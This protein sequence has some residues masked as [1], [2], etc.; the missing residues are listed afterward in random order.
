MINKKIITRIFFLLFIT[1]NITVNAQVEISS[2][3]V[4]SAYTLDVPGEFTLKS[5]I[6]VTFKANV[7]CDSFPTINVNSTGAILI[8]KEGGTTN[9]LDK[10]IRG[11]QVVNL[12][13]DGT[14]WQMLSASGNSVA[15]SAW[16]LTGNTGTVDG[17]NFIG[18][19]DNIPFNIRVNN[20][21]AGRID[22]TLFN[23]FFGYQAG[24]ANTTGLQNIASGGSSLLNNTTASR[25][26]AI[27]F[28]AL[29]TQSFNNAGTAWNT[30]NIAIGVE[31]LFLN[32]PTSTVNGI[33]NTAIGNYVLRFNTTGNY[34]SA[35]GMNA[36]RFNTT[37]NEN[38]AIGG[39]ALYLNNTGNSN[40]ANGVNALYSNTSGTGNM[41]LG[42]Q[43]GYTATP[44][45]ANT[46][47]SYNVFLGYNSGPGV[48][49]ASNLQNAIAIGKNALVNASNSMVL[50]GTGGD[51]VNVGVGTASPGK[52]TGASHYV[53]IAQGDAYNNENISLE[54]QGSTNTGI[55]GNVARIDFGNYTASS[56]LIARIESK[57]DGSGN[58]GN[59]IFSTHNGTALSEA[60]RVDN[61][62]QVGIGT[63]PSQKFEL[64]DGN[65]LVSNS[66]A[67]GEIRL[68]EPAAS[69]TNYT[70]F[71][72]P[73]QAANI[74]YTLPASL[75]AGNF[76][77][78]DASGNLSWAALP[79][80][81]TASNGLTK[82]VNDIQLGGTL[83]AN[84]TIS[85]ANFNMIYNLA[86]TGNFD[87]QDAGTSK[88]YVKNTGFVGINN[89]APSFALDVIGSGNG[90][91]IAA[92]DNNLTNGQVLYLS[93]AST[94]GTGGSASKIITI[95]RS[96]A[97]SIAS[98][99]AYGINSSVTNT[100]STS[101]NIS[102]YFFASG[103][104]NNY[105]IVVPS[106]G[107]KVGI[108]TTSPIAALDVV[109]QIYSHGYIVAAGSAIDWNN[110]NN[111][112][113]QAV[114]GG[115]VTF[116]NMQDGGNYTAII[117][118]ATSR[119]YTFSQAG[120]TFY[121][122]PPNGPTVAAQST[123]YRFNRIG[124]SVY[125]DWK[126]VGNP[127][128]TTWGLTGNSGTVDGTN[129]I[130][131][132]D[133]I[134][135]NFRVN[136]LKAGRIEP[137][138]LGSV[139]FGYLAGISTNAGTLNTA[140][141]AEAL[142][143]NTSGLFNTAIGQGALSA[144]VTGSSNTAN[145]V[146]ALTNSTGSNNTAIGE[147][148][149]YNNIGG[150]NNTA[151]GYHA[152]YTSSTGS[153][154]TFIGYGADLYSATQHSK[155]AAIGYNAKVDADNAI[156]LGG[157]GA[158][159]VNV[160]IGTTIPTSKLE[161]S[162][163]I[164]VG[165]G[166]YSNIR[167]H[168]ETSQFGLYS[169]KT[170]YKGAYFILN[171]AGHFDTPGSMVFTHGDY[172]APAPASSILFRY[173]NNGGISNDFAIVSSGNVGIGTI[174][175][176]SRLAIVSFAAD[177]AG[178]PST[179]INLLNNSNGLGPW[180]Q[181]GIWA[182]GSAGYNGDLIFG[183]DGDGI[184]NVNITEKM[185]IKTDG[186]VIIGTCATPP[187]IG[188]A[189]LYVAGAIRASTLITTTAL[190]CSDLRFKKEIKPLHNSLEKVLRMQGV[191]YYWK[192]DEFPDW[193]F[194]NKKQIGFIAQDVEK[195]FP[196]LVNTD[197]DSLGY[198]SVDYSKLTPVLVEALKELNVKMETQQQVIQSLTQSVG[199]LK[200]ENVN[201]KKSNI[202]LESDFE[203]IKAQL[204][205]NF[206]VKK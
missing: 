99:T 87:I 188:T 65:F 43:A 80:S 36:L 49:S 67:A 119:T 187:T 23:T 122:T 41:A 135:L 19:S 71:K 182:D 151:I 54:L 78:T 108:G 121:F 82:V 21:K 192:K 114:G 100:G 197:E 199:V 145:G 205:I 123:L 138:S 115:A 203:K 149:L 162:G 16:S 153:N 176:P 164:T 157:T 59:I 148:S 180:G 63:K 70:A 109:G 12:V 9:L 17:T 14:Y 1:A 112:V 105:A 2:G 86:G 104:T 136:N 13:Y 38:I 5:G 85:Q 20:Q 98:H 170:S 4:G 93:S 26:I 178:V 91:T 94:T 142:Y 6:Q 8:K 102:G 191:N 193:E 155:A 107:G 111:Q 160:G 69:G 206:E 125:V 110:G 130:G 57:T 141:G 101:T 144:N 83:T 68:A 15:G 179:G 79:A 42:F 33:Q 88:F 66:S 113:L 152:G 32:Q 7:V 189:R 195:I 53:T 64:K 173:A 97:N 163:E 194:G 28:K 134:S 126:T 39:Y 190:A 146:Q 37:G 185:R 118:D 74:T 124:T 55:D 116:V 34:N 184:N 133:N 72:A 25:N 198:K 171:S 147:S 47:G 106:G 76:L 156:V 35:I 175:P 150:G 204:G 200:E 120:L 84:T 48:A 3:G 95:Q 56:N 143:S 168:N 90:T 129:F 196:E 140:I 58:M 103:A 27:G 24:N 11:G 137:N 73:V 177:G 77:S 61:S 60:M 50:G 181:G 92:Q 18:T 161:V 166:I 45:N 139:A 127:L 75:T 10:D 52:Y 154:N 51:A 186:R 128:P 30:D 131:T 202:Q 172:T 132:S 117:T 40:T 96:G 46:I 44:A 159:A 62:G 22:P 158:D 201:L 29:N 174:T 165:T 89:S 183:T 167:S 81:P 31:A 169:S